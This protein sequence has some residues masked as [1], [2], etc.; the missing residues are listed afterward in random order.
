M[1]PR[2][3]CL[4]L[5]LQPLLPFLLYSQGREIDL[6][7]ITRRGE[8]SE[9][10][11]VAVIASDERVQNLLR[12]A[13]NAHG[14][15][16]VVGLDD[17]DFTFRFT[18]AGERRVRVDIE[19]G[20]PA[21]TLFS[22]EVEGSSRNNA[23][24]RAA[25][26]AVSRTV[27]NLPGIFAGTIAF[28][29]DRSGPS[30][31]LFQGDLFFTEVRQLT[32][33][34]AKC[35]LPSLSPDGRYILY[36]SYHRSGFPDLYRV[37][38]ESGRRAVFAGFRGTNTGGVWN[39]RGDRVAMILSGTGNAELYVSDAEGGN[40]RRL[41]K[42]AALE[43]DPSW[44][45]DG[46]R[47]VFA[48]DAPGRPQLHVMPATGGVPR[49]IPTDISGYCAEPVWNPRDENLI[50][51][52]IAAGGRF[53]IALYD[54][55]ARRSRIITNGPVDAIEPI[56]TRDGRHLIYTERSDRYRRLMLLDTV[57]GSKA[58]LHD[59]GFGDAWQAAYA[60]P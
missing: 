50:A 11:P 20:R 19:S 48:S 53:E 40:L 37:E 6:G 43:A 28:I 14:A 13:F 7:A 22:R 35:A 3:L 41:T 23:A 2:F 17:A 42:T 12:H 54:F 45:P 5:A 49:R 51:F 31:E 56:W 21:E 27:Q 58:P 32:R 55:E 8:A 10:R 15:Y 30:R 34:G 60:Y 47:L 38:V 36:T 29:S 39:P 57:T 24:L 4:V 46:R 9:S 1:S 44:S 33:D 26:L 16:R 59:R 52:T 18:V 25:D